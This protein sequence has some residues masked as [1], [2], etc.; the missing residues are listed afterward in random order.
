[1]LATAAVDPKF[2]ADPDGR[3]PIY[4][5]RSEDIRRIARQLRQEL[6]PAAFA[7]IELRVLPDDPSKL[8]EQGLLYLPRAVRGAGRPLQRDVWLGQFLHPDRACCT[9]ERLDLAKDM[10][11]NFLYEIREYGKILNANR[12]YYLTRSQPPFLTR[13]VAGCL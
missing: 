13:N 12:T 8:D 3:W 5:S 7:K 9:M 1:M 4:V 11:D 6:A 10:A 2:H